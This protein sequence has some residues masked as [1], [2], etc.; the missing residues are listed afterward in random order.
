MGMRCGRS[1]ALG[2]VVSAVAHTQQR[3]VSRRRCLQPRSCSSRT[4]TRSPS[5]APTMSAV[6][7]RF[8]SLLII[9]SLACLVTPAA[10][11]SS[12]NLDVTAVGRDPRWTIV[13]RTTS[14]VDIKGRHA[15]KLDEGAGIGVVWLSGGD[16]LGGGPAP[17][18]CGPT[19]PTQGSFFRGG[20][21]AFGARGHEAGD[22]RPFHILPSAPARP[23]PP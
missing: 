5:G 15:L 7:C 13:G 3:L 1:D 19:Q 18:V 9:A 16:F 6:P 12:E 22:R 17:P 14:I 23:D 2:V 8:P 4:A 21:F 11:Q 20:G 10:A